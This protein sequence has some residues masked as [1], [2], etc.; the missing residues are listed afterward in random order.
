MIDI[1]LDKWIYSLLIKY[2]SDTDAEI[3]SKRPAPG[4]KLQSEVEETGLVAEYLKK[5][6]PG[7]ARKFQVC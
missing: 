5:V 7:I 6:T 4:R 2:S 1:E 3:K